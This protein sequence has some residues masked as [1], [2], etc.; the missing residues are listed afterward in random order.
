MN[1]TNS[2]LNILSYKAS[3]NDGLLSL[4]KKS[5]STSS[6]PPS[7]DVNK[8]TEQSKAPL[9]FFGAPFKDFKLLSRQ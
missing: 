9:I 6:G 7:S 3:K 4:Q 2:I 8:L 5:P 1:N